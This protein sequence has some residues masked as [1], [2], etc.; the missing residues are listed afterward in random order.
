MFDRSMTRAV[1]LLPPSLR[2]PLRDATGSIVSPQQLD[3]VGAALSL[4]VSKL[5]STGELARLPL[6]DEDK[7]V[8]LVSLCVCVSVCVCVCVRMYVFVELSFMKGP[9]HTVR[10]HSCLN[11]L[12]RSDS[13]L[14]TF[15]LLRASA[16]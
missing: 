9:S 5:V 4:A 11:R 3:D 6:R 10:V 8:M 13:C 1:E 15:T 14:T 2:D 12:L 7:K 16:L